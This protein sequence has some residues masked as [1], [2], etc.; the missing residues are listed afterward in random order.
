MNGNKVVIA[1]LLKAG[2]L[3]VLWHLVY[4][5]YLEVEGTFIK[6]VAEHVAAVSTSML[7][8]MGYNA[9]QYLHEDGYATEIGINQVPV[10][11]IDSGCTGLTLMALFA[12]FIVA[13]PGPWQRKAWYIPVGLF[14]IYLINF[15]R[16]II[17]AVARVSMSD[18]SFDFNHKYTYTLFTYAAIFGLWMLW[19][20]R[21]SG[22]T[23]AGLSTTPNAKP[24][25]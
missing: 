2:A 20:N 12:G 8:I 23:L 25:K 15:F 6:S 1:F 3:Y 22:I 13:Y 9:T 18:T 17:L 14:A 10:V 19:A 24:S 11:W 5:R 16:V 21:L 7:S 4:Q